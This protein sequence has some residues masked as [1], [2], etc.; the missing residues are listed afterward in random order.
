M[1]VGLNKIS[2]FILFCSFSQNVWILNIRSHRID[3]R[4]LFSWFVNSFRNFGCT[5]IVLVVAHCRG[6][7]I[8][9]GLTGDTVW[10]VVDVAWEIIWIWLGYGHIEAQRGCMLVKIR[11][12]TSSKLVR[13]HQWCTTKWIAGTVLSQQWWTVH[14]WRSHQ[15]VQMVWQHGITKC[16]TKCS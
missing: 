5:I 2:W 15:L 11:K 14:Y 6:H 4:W 8:G 13:I 1:T 10:R 7:H 9:S 12:M 3:V 16:G